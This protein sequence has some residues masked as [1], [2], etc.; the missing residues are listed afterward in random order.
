MKL[1]TSTCVAMR[2]QHK[3][4]YDLR[5]TW[6]ENNIEVRRHDFGSN[7][8]PNQLSTFLVNELYTV[9][10]TAKFFLT[11]KILLVSSSLKSI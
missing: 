8:F 3:I 7:T 2:L 10:K 5:P 11:K 9:Y 6:I 1:L 4:S